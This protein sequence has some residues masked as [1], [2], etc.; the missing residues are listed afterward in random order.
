MKFRLTAAARLVFVA[1]AF[2][3]IAC[4]PHLSPLT[5]T[6]MPASA[7]PRP[8]MPPGRAKIVFNW[9]L[10]DRETTTRGEGAAR[11]A[12]P[13]SAR[14][15]FFLAGGFAGGSAVLIGDSI[16]APGGDFIRKLIPPPPMLWAAL[17]RLALPN[18]P[19]TVI[20]GEG[21]STRADVG[22]P[23]SWRL[24]F[25]GDSLIRVE[26]V[27]Q[28]RVLE[29]VDRSDPKHVSYRNTVARRS[30]QLTITRMD[31]V[32]SFDASIWRLD[33]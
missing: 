31:E 10:Q 30:L 19:D 22:R 28:D 14:L 17:G 23:V 21:T 27:D 1:T 20:R 24:T 15:D 26:R 16:Q 25:H 13:D 3:V 6:P 8:G 7:L 12:S 5:G 33:R 29:W 4:V 9:E 2:F 11:I 18:L 32:S